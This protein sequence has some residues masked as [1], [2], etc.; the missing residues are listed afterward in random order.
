MTVAAGVG[1]VDQEAFFTKRVA[2]ADLSGYWRVS[3]GDF[4]YNKS[5]SKSAP[6]GVNARLVGD[7]DAIVTPLYFV[8]RPDDTVD[9]EFFELMI[10]SDAFFRSLSGR[11]REGARA[12]GALNVRLHEFFSAE[13]PLPPRKEQEAIVAI[14]R[15]VDDSIHAF[16]DELEA[17]R[18]AVARV[19]VGLLAAGIRGDWQ[20]A[21]A[22]SHTVITWT[23][24]LPTGWR[25]ATVGAVSR[26]RSGA[27][28]R[29]LEQARYFDGGTIPWVKTGD[30]NER[31]VVETDE[32]L[33]DAGLAESSA[34]M[35]DVDTVLVAMYGGYAQIGRTARL[36]VRAATNQAI[37]ALT[38]LAPDVL[39]EFLHEALK[40]G[41]SKWRLV[42]ASSR[43]DPNITKRDVE[44][45]DFPLPPLAEQREIVNIVA[46]ME[47]AVDA[48]QANVDRLR[49]FRR[50]LV[51]ALMSQDVRAAA[52][53]YTHTGMTM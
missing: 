15:A 8:F 6:F 40:A 31:V 23:A 39:P 16:D 38:E 24:R 14:V 22:D 9:H 52:T 27:T 45:F 26:V 7:T 2:S 5:A 32:R 43:K 19:R 47:Q 29:R 42:A 11:L 46:P 18:N 33:T 1:L 17:L 10:N 30:L 37:S 25:R 48:I 41:R 36:G 34:R 35:L 51:A 49:E 21:D 44:A 50:R 20:T 53:L 12:H 28:P 3:P 4:V 13:V